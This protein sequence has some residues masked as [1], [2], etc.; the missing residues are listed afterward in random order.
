MG[1]PT[2]TRLM[3][4]SPVLN[5]S[6]L[7]S[8]VTRLRLADTFSSVVQRSPLR[9][10]GTRFSVRS[11][12]SQPRL[13]MLPTLANTLVKPLVLVMGRSSSRSRVSLV[14][15]SSVR[16][17]RSP[18]TSRSTPTSSWRVL[19]HL[20]SGLERLLGARPGRSP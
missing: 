18:S 10:A 19:S 17:T 20:R 8:P 7:K 1:C 2:S 13:R 11:A 6:S 3:S 16:P 9:S 12:T 15:Q 14:Y 5:G 4:R